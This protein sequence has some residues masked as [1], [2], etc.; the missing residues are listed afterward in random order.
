[1]KKNGNL[2]N[3]SLTLKRGERES[4]F[5]KPVITLREYIFRSKEEYNTFMLLPKGRRKLSQLFV[6]VAL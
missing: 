4:V 6:L 1:M 2:K 3:T 5:L